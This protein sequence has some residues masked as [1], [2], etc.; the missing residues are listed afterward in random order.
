MDRKLK[1]PTKSSRLQ[2]LGAKFPGGIPRLFHLIQHT[3]T[4]GG[5]S[6]IVEVPEDVPP[7]RVYLSGLLV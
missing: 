3:A 2:K 7:A 6:S 5:G 1:L 4:G